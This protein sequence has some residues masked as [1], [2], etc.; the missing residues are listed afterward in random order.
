MKISAILFENVKDLWDQAAAKPFVVEMAKGILDP[1]RYRYYMVQ[2]YL[3]LLRYVDILECIRESADDE[4]LDAFI[5]FVIDQVRKETT[6]VHVPNMKK[7]G[8]TEVDAANS[9]QSPEIAE[10][11]SYMLSCVKQEGVLAGLT[12]QL[13][14]SWVYAYIGQRM[15]ETYPDEIAVSPYKGWFEAYTCDDYTGA[16]QKWIDILDEKA[17]GVEGEEAEKLCRIFRTCAGYENR[18]WDMLYHPQQI[19]EGE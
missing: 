4:K 5:G 8:I 7:L 16:N 18:F 15:L 11:A 3:Y 6:L 12:A 17:E 1:D 10:Y 2:D 19:Q 14:C 9:P 13:Q